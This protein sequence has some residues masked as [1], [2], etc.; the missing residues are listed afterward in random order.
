[1]AGPVVKPAPEFVLPGNSKEKVGNKTTPHTLIMDNLEKYLTTTVYKGRGNARGAIVNRL[2]ENIASE[3][4]GHLAHSMDG[5][6]PSI[7][8]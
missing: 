1:M 5:P 7:A 6:G 8:V 3:I 2:I 4:F